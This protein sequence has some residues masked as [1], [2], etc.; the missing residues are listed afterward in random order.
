MPRRTAAERHTPAPAVPD[1]RDGTTGTDRTG[2]QAVEIEPTVDALVAISHPLRRRLLEVLR[3]DGPASVG[4]LAA[5][6]EVAVGSI[7][8]HAKTLYRNGFIEPAPEL[9][10]DTRESWWRARPVTLSWSRQDF[11]PGTPARQVAEYAARANLERHLALIRSSVEFQD[12]RMPGWERAGMISDQLVPATQEQ[13]AEL[14]AVLR[15]SVDA[16]RD[17]VRADA[18]D[19]PDL[20]RQ[21]IFVATYVLPVQP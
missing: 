11:A 4:A 7:S 8:H 14:A 5:R 18:S 12:E 9:A 16:W 21:P 10:R 17:R 15:A 2:G 3:V 1:V 20:E 19:H 13:V 6:L